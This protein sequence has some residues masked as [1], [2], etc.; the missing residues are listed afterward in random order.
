[1]R[2]R[3]ASAWATAVIVG[4]IFGWFLTAALAHPASTIPLLL[5]AIFATIVWEVLIHIAFAVRKAPE[6]ID[7]EDK[8]IRGTARLFGLGALGLG[9]LIT[10]V[11]VTTPGLIH[12]LPLL[13]DMPRSMLLLDITAAT[14]A[15]AE[16]V[17][18]GATISLY[19]ANALSHAH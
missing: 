13:R 14:L 11:S 8:R 16:I 4:V 10:I 5:R 19:R 17:K 7:T 15:F 18:S 2:F 12:N 3:E 6:P 9:T 1:M